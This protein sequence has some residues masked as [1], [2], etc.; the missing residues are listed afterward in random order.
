MAGNQLGKTVAGGNEFAMHLTGQYPKWWEGRR[1]EDPVK[2]WASG[3]TSESTRDNPQRILMGPP[4]KESEWGT[5]AI[6]YK[7][8]LDTSRAIG[9]RDFLDTVIVKHISGGDS[10][11]SFK[12]YEKGRTK[13]QGETLHGVWFDE[14]PPLEIYIEGL[15]R[16]NAT[17]GI[18]VTTF[19]PLLGMSEVV[20]MFISEEEKKEMQ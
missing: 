1:F 8:I 6:P 14:E 9:I 17:M 20:R 10:Y 15:T 2:M 18:A 4:A 12:T 3:V 19:T 7:S 5:G 16:T 11:L 13:W